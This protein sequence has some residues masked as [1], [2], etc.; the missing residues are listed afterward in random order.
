[1]N[2]FKV[3]DEGNLTP[4][5]LAG[6]RQAIKDRE[7]TLR[8]VSAP[9]VQAGGRVRSHV[10]VSE[11]I[12]LGLLSA[13]EASSAA[14]AFLGWPEPGPTQEA[15]LGVLGALDR[16]LTAHVVLLRERGPV[17]AAS[18]LAITQP[19][20]HGELALLAATRLANA[21]RA[22]L[23]VATLVPRDASPEAEAEAAADLEARTGDVVRATVTT[24]RGTL[25]EAA[26]ALAPYT[27]FIVCGVPADDEGGGDLVATVVGLQTI[28]GCSFALVRANPDRA[29]DFGIQSA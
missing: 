23:T 6:Y 7:R 10:A 3:V 9:I 5:H 22:E 2:V 26:A 15:Q 19:G 27:E 8:E 16:N 13:A 17:A 18:I 14:V 1:M 24:M 4:D 25:T 12:L 28:E 29:L 21:W 20:V 11:S